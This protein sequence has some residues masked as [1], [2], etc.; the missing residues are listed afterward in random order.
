M[1][2]E[3]PENLKADL[4][5]TGWGRILGM[6]PVVMTVIATALAGLAS[7]E[8]TRAQYDRS[9]AAQLQSK[10][11]DQWGLFQAKKLRSAFQ[12]TAFDLLASSFELHPLDA[13]AL[14]A[15][16]EDRTA[17]ELLQHGGSPESAAAP[18][19]DGEIKA[20]IGAVEAS[21]PD[22]E[23]A[24]LLA[25]VDDASLDRALRAAE[26]QVQALDAADQPAERAIAQLDSVLGP[27]QKGVEASIRR[28]FTALRLRRESQRYDSEAR[29][30]QAIANIYELQ[31]RKANISAERHHVRSQ[32]FFYGMLG[33]QMAVIISALSIAAR[34]R[35]LLWSLAAAA[36]LG[37]VS[38]AVYVYLSV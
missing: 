32:R 28:D 1:K 31:V 24:G 27:A 18:A 15:A 21:S 6:T 5:P 30:N 11:G 13:S 35:N 34:Q 23:I 36:G 26:D 7:S 10:A 9:L 16:A 12:K 33:A 22:S 4:P 25:H 20:A 3:I 17:V 29:L 2:T 38:F 19:T 8:M 37:A 14:P